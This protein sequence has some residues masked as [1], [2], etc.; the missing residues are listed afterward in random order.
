LPRCF[1]TKK[2]TFPLQH[3]PMRRCA[4]VGHV[5]QGGH[6]LLCPFQSTLVWDFAQLHP[7]AVLSAL[8][9]LAGKT[10]SYVWE[11]WEKPE[12]PSK[13]T[14]QVRQVQGCVTNQYKCGAGLAPVEEPVVGA[15][16]E[17]EEG[18]FHSLPSIAHFLCSGGQVHAPLQNSSCRDQGPASRRSHSPDSS[19][20]VPS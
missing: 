19:S 9:E 10:K 8:R 1:R 18:V 16:E 20:Q 7:A 4:R 6:S 15:G 12:H 3:M 2:T 13:E 14:Q 5:E 11:K 17:W